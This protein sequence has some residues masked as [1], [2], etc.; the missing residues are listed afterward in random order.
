V[1]PADPVTVTISGADARRIA[2][3]AQGF[4]DPRPRGRVDRRHLR[5]VLDRIGLIQIDSVN[6]LVRSQELPLFARL[7]PHPRTLIDDATRAGELF[8][9][10]VHE[11]SLVPVDQYHLYRWRM[12]GP[13]PWPSFRRRIQEL[14]GFIEEIYQRVV[15]D[16]P[17]VAGDLKTRVGK[18]GTW[19]DYDDGKTALEALFFQGR[20]TARRRPQ[21]FARVYD[22][23]E[24]MIPAAELARPAPT[25]HDAFKE[26]LVLA[27]TYHGLG[28]LQDL[29]DYHRLT[30]TVAKPALVELVEE[31]RL[32]PVSVEGW[33]RPAY[34]LPGTRLRRRV[35]ARALLSPFDPVVWN[36]ARA[37]RLFDFHYR[38]EIYT[39]APKRRYG[40]YVLPF[41]LGDDLVGRVD[42]KADRANGALLV[43]S[44]WTEPGVDEREVAGELL[45]ELRL[46]ASWLDLGHIHVTGRG[47]L[48]PPFDRC[49]SSEA[50]AGLV[51][52]GVL[53]DDEGR[54]LT[55]L[56][57]ACGDGCLDPLLGDLPR[58]AHVEVEPLS[59][60]LRSAL[61]EPDRGQV[62]V[63]AAHLVVRARVVLVA[64][65][66]PPERLDPL[67][68]G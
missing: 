36:R 44:A 24:R 58:Y 9:Y 38:I 57:A 10:W 4:A 17:L 8:E 27:A 5:R 32:V 59:R 45:E 66:G 6:V 37:L 61:L 31:G 22:I 29:A 47:D 65:H 19:W 49:S 11:A 64:Q 62:G 15:E 1:P 35:D 53:Q 18:K 48:G 16:G 63:V 14:G 30:P 52:L 28:T 40:Y 67:V 25:A 13:F 54:C 2:L 42:L 21:D 50:D 23:P 41:L 33:D 60:L 55:H 56:P 68:V 39:P 26:L 3:A 43:Q 7:G 34:M 46:M 51:A 12:T 20:I